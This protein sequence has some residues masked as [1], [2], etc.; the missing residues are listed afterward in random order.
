[1]FFDVTIT[2]GLQFIEGSDGGE[3]F[4]SSEVFFNE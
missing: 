4:F 2:K 3:Y 1:M